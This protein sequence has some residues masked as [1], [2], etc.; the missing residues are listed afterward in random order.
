MMTDDG[1]EAGTEAQDEENA[2]EL[3]F[4]GSMPH[5]ARSD[6][7]V[8]VESPKSV[9]QADDD[10]EL[11]LELGTMPLSPHS[12]PDTSEDGSYMAAMHDVHGMMDMERDPIEVSRCG[13]LIPHGEDVEESKVRGCCQA[14]HAHRHA[15]SW[16]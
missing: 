11:D 16:T 15:C 2:A 6:I 4:E 9:Y 14:A 5:L 3:S 7:R 12:N 10:R 8:T 1:Y 13:H